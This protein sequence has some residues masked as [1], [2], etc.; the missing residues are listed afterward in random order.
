MGPQ[1]TGRK[2]LS[3]LCNDWMLSAAVMTKPT[4]LMQPQDRLRA[5]IAKIFLLV[6]LMSLNAGCG[7]MIQNCQQLL[8]GGAGLCPHIL[9]AVAL[10]EEQR[11][12]RS[13]QLSEQ[14]EGRMCETVLRQRVSEV[15]SSNSAVA[16]VKD[17]DLKMYHVMSVQQSFREDLA[18]HS[19]QFSCRASDWSRVSSAQV[20]LQFE[21]VELH[22]IDALGQQ[23]VPDSM[24]EYLQQPTKAITEDVSVVRG[25]QAQAWIHAI[26]SRH[27]ESMK[28]PQKRASTVHP[29][30]SEA[31]PRYSKTRGPAGKKARIVILGNFQE[32][33]PDEFAASKAPGYSSLRIALSVASRMGW[34]IECWDASTAFLYAGLFRDLDTD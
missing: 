3:F 21:P 20:P 19:Y 11:N 27:L 13:Q 22:V 6:T 15:S 12:E 7:P 8:A 9:N 32:V 33:H 23:D 31:D 34:P 24:A 17:S 29:M 25:P 10:S 2:S 14:G 30:T 5:R 18:E 1:F 28:K 26:S 4:P 16:V